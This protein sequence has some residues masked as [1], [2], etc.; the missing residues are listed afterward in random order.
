MEI[1][2]R[3]IQRCQKYYKRKCKK[4]ISREDVIEIIK[5]HIAINDMVRGI[6]EAVLMDDGMNME[7]FNKFVKVMVRTGGVGQ[8]DLV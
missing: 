7:E 1:S 5:V 3:L 6:Y 2:E 4:E 8:E